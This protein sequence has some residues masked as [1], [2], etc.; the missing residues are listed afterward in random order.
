[1]VQVLPVVLVVM[2]V[3]I[4]ALPFQGLSHLFG[5]LSAA[6]T[7]LAMALAGV[8]LVSTA[9]D[10]SDAD[11]TEAPLMRLM[12]QMLAL[13]LPLPAALAGWAVW[14]RVDQYGLTPNRLAAAMAALLALGYGV[15][16]AAAVLRR[17]RWMARIRLANTWLALGG[18]VLA[19]LWLTPVL[20]AQR[21]SA[22][23]QLARY[24]AGR[25]ALA[26]L[27]LALL[28]SLENQSSSCDFRPIQMGKALRRM[29]EINEF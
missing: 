25:T 15:A 4:L 17:G 26:N 28:K 3:F 8:T 23:S 11:A 27:D 9:V 14:L 22:A 19:A 1:M 2:S 24:E 21:L 5:D 10:Q 16:Y 13:L 18:V 12:T 20:N 6:A 29:D 7:L